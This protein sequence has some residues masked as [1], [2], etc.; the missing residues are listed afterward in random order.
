[1]NLV[2]D[3]G[4][5]RTKIAV[6][7][8]SIPEDIRIISRDVDDCLH[9][10]LNAYPVKAC[11]FSSVAKNSA[12]RT[13]YLCKEIPLFIR[14]DRQTK[15]PV[16]VDY[17]TPATLGADRIAAVAGVLDYEAQQALVIDAGTAVTYDL[18]TGSTVFSGGNIAPGVA[19][20]LEAL[21]T[22]TGR[23]PLVK[24]EGEVPLIGY[25]TATAIR[26][27]VI[28]G[29]AYEMEGYIGEWKKIYPELL[30]FLT[31]GDAFLFAD[32][33]KTSIFV[34]KN[35]VLKGLNRILE[36]NVEK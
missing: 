16:T 24:A 23:L 10:L 8:S 26:S 35:L 32:K 33:L 21:H 20:R 11:I 15:V 17:R 25:D 31:G 13:D 22:R 2:I 1:M 19:M 36:Y 6:F 18:L 28:R 9:D 34:D 3:E 29:M 30:V 5:T 27:G 4:N 14:F 7:R 12:L